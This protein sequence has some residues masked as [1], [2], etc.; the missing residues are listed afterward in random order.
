MEKYDRD[1]PNP[2]P[3]RLKFEQL[4]ADYELFLQTFEKPT[5]IYR[6]LRSR[7]SISPLF[8]HR[9]LSYLKDRRS[10]SAVGPG[11]RRQQFEIEDLLEK[12]KSEIEDILEKDPE[13]LGCQKENF[14]NITFDGFFHGPE[15]G[16]EIFHTSDLSKQAS[17]QDEFVDVNLQLIKIFARKKRG[18]EFPVNSLDLGKCTSSWNPRTKLMTPGSSCSIS[19]P[20]K[21]FTGT[22][23]TVKTYILSIQVSVP[24]TKK[25]S[26]RLPKMKM[27]PEDASETDKDTDVDSTSSL[28]E[29]PSKKLRRQPS[30]ESNEDASMSEF[31]KRVY[32]AELIVFDKHKNCLLTN[33]E[34][35]LLLRNYNMEDSAD[36]E[37]GKPVENGPRGKLG[38]F[39]MFA[40][41]PTIKF[42]LSWKDKPITAFQTRSAALIYNLAKQQNKSKKA[43]QH[44]LPAVVDVSSSP[45]QEPRSQAPLRIFYQFIYNNNTRQQTEARDDYYCP[46]CSINCMRLYSLLKH[47]KTYH[48]RFIF[49]YTSLSK[50]AR[51]D[52]CIN[53]NYEFAS[54]GAVGSIKP[55]VGRDIPSRRQQMTEVIV[56][57]PFTERE[58]LQ[59]FAEPDCTD[60]D[61]VK[62]FIKGHDRVYYHSD[63]CVP[64]RPQE[65]DYDSEDHVTPNWVKAQAEFMIDEFTDVNEGEKDLMKIWNMHI[66]NGCY[67]SDFQM[68]MACKSFVEE[69]SQEIVNKNLSKNLLLHLTNLCEFN[70]ISQATVLSTMNIF[71]NIVSEGSKDE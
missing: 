60:I 39:E 68:P 56:A 16:E 27:S 37:Q 51:I 36:A 45:K 33:G 30:A 6:Y 43:G 58:D 55:L 4:R 50:G 42:K 11:T 48:S 29:P 59:E 35:E 61:G 15:F 22:G 66:I 12:R 25:T 49:M 5:Q 1:S 28:S 52:V 3:R 10:K 70:L 8:L 46:W 32:T 9:S 18:E 65:I 54:S 26:R 40:F 67:I 53:E 34:Y 57:R 19:I 20:R 21:A 7:H 47:L 63:T 38:P 24:V 23:K 71:R 17:L 31:S 41:G 69:H 13:N 44:Q 14:L 62:P 2:S 64:M